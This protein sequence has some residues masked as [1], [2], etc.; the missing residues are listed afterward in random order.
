MF[1]KNC[2][3]GVAALIIMIGFMISIGSLEIFAEADYG[4]RSAET[5]KIDVELNDDFF[6]PD[7]I[8]ISAGQTTTL[9]LNNK[10]M[11]RH[12]FT[13]EKLEID[14]ELQ[15][16]EVKTISVGPV[17]P[18]TYELICR[19]HFNEGMVGKVIVN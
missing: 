10:G 4:L 6:K 3:T 16:G 14:A 17:K 11:K 5:R 12:T 13:V 18:G 8:T 2:F 15:P 19:F 1:I 9:V 7:T